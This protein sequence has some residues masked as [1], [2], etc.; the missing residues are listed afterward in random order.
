VR[1]WILFSAT[2][3]LLFG[4]AALLVSTTLRS[5]GAASAESVP[6]ESL[7]REVMGRVV[8]QH[9]G[10]VDEEAAVYGAMK[11]AAG[12]LDPH[13]R[14]FDAAEW[15][16]FQRET[17]GEDSGIG[18]RI[19][20]LDG[21]VIVGWVA[22]EGP[23][24][25]AG[26]RAGD[27]IAAIAG[28]P[29][30]ADPAAL[31]RGLRGP[32]GT[33]LEL[34][35]ADR[36]DG[37]RRSVRVTRGPF[38]IGTVFAR[39]LE[40]PRVLY[41]RVT[42]FKP[43]TTKAFE[44]VLRSSPLAAIAGMILDLRFNRGGAFD[45]AV[46]MADAWMDDGVIVTTRGPGREDARVASAAAPLRSVPTVVLVNGSTAS[47]AEIVAGALQD[48]HAALLVGT[49]TFGKGVVQEAFEF[50]TWGGG[51]R[52]TTARYFTPAGRCIDRSFAARRGN[53]ES[54]GLLPD[55]VVPVAAD[56]EADLERALD[57]GAFPDWLKERLDATAP[58]LEG[59]DVQLE[60]A[61]RV[62]EGRAP[63]RPLAGEAGPGSGR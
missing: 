37:R 44:D 62:L 57:R 45:P 8:R 24:D 29:D 21:A 48:V 10:P 33:A 18:I 34:V 51:M 3:A 52:L 13:S 61:L 36:D 41:C 4:S 12:S 39:V 23:A 38:E 55:V 50:E 17:R 26:I 32:A 7:Y 31:L 2:L 60:A 54:R 22:R 53:G 56:S 1:S 15:V 63:D 47:A 28:G 40:K 58:I 16:E 19:A 5:L 14:V 9:V 49:R 20:L 59:G 27:R 42:G 30:D 6:G 35:I 25:E 46:A 11:G 43:H